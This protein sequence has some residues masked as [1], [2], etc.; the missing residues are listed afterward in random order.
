PTSG[1]RDKVFMR[2]N[3]RERMT[4]EIRSLAVVVA[5]LAAVS[6]TGCTTGSSSAKAGSGTHAKTS[7]KAKASSKPSP[8]YTVSQQQAIGSAQDYLKYSGFSRK[9]LIQQLSSKAG[10]GFKLADAVFA[11]NHIKV[12]WNAQAVRS[13]KDYLKL[14]HFSCSG[15]V[16]QLSSAA[17]DGYTL[18]QA[19][20]AGKKVGLC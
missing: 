8:H 14:S 15:L 11:V 19:Q 5:L 2:S 9:G 18:P 20:Y 17:G 1:I 10:E 16:Q 13:A 4:M 7:K 3:R 12:D 6:I